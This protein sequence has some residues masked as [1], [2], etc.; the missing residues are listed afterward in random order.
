MEILRVTSQKQKPIWMKEYKKKKVQMALLCS[1]LKMS[2]A[3]HSSQ[4]ASVR[5]FIQLLN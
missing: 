4:S 5:Y 3:V 1:P 2:M